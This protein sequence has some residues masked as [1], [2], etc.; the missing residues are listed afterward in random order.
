MTSTN[1]KALEVVAAI[2]VALERE[3]KQFD[4]TEDCDRAKMAWWIYQTF[5]EGDF[6]TRAMRRDTS[7]RTTGPQATIKGTEKTVD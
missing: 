6:I 4:L 3:C 5:G 1:N 7:K 2:D